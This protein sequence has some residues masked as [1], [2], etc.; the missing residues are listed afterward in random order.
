MRKNGVFL[1]V[2]SSPVPEMFTF[3][4]YANKIADDA[5]NGYSMWSNHKMKN[6]SAKND[7]MQLKLHTEYWCQVS[8]VL[9]C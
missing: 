2:V 7:A 4:C 9:H 8:T 1:C 5:I 6:I 3:L